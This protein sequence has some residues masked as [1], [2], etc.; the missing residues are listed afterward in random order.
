MLDVGTAALVNNHMLEDFPITSKPIKQ[1][2][3]SL[4][5]LLLFMLGPII[6]ISKLNFTY[7]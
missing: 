2:T 3:Q 1:K 7:V 5:S 6:L 4:F